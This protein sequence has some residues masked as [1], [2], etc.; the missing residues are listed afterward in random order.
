MARIFLSHSSTNNTEAIALRDWLKREGWEDVFLDV[1]PDR[2]IAAGQRWE[3][4]LHEAAS[5]CEAVLFLVSRAWL[6]SGWCLK[7]FN[8]A[9]KLNKRLF[10]LLVEDI[11]V[12]ELPFNLTS[13]WQLV[14]LC[15]S[16]DHVMLR[17]NLPFTGTEAHVT[18]SVEA[19]GRLKT[20]LQRAGLD[21][22]FFAWPPEDDPNRPPYR[23]LKPLEASDAGIF[24]GRDAAIVETLDLLRGM[25][26]G[27]PPRLPAILGASGAG[28][29]SF[30]RAGLL[31]RLARDDEDF[32]PLPIVRPERTVL[33]GDTGLLNALERALK[34][35]RIAITRAELRVAIKG[36]A[37]TLQ[38]YLQALV[39]KATR[40]ALDPGA[41]PKTPVLVL[42]IDQGE[43]L[44]L[45]E[46]QGESQDFLALLRALLTEDSPAIMAILTIRSD[47]YERL[48]L[49][50]E[51]DGLRQMTLSLPAMPR[52]SYS[53]VI[54]GPPQ[55][56]AETARAF[57]I[58]DRLVE[59]LL[60]DIEV[61]GGAKDALPLLAFTLERLY[62][63]FHAGGNLQLAHYNELGRIGGSI[64][65]AVNHALEAANTDPEVP[66]DRPRRLALL[67]QG[68]I[69]WLAGVDADTGAPR[70]RVAR[71]SEI[72]AEARPLIRHFVEQRLLTTDIARDT[73]EQTIEPAHEALLR[74]WSLL[75]GWL[76]EDAGLLAVMDGVKRAARDWAAHGK[77]HSWLTHVTGRLEA[78]ERLGARPD[79]AAH[80]LPV[81]REYLAACRKSENDGN[82]RKRR[83]QALVYILLVGIIVGLVGWMNQAAIKDEVNW[84]VTMRPYM[85][86]EVR[87][88]V[89][90]AEAERAL[91]PGS[92]FRECGRIC[93][94]MVV[95]PPG[96]FKMGSPET[97]VGHLDH[98]ENEGP[99]H[100]VRIATPF[101]VSKLDVTFEAWDACVAV[102]GCPRLS[103]S[104]WGRGQQPVINVTWIEAQQYATWFSRMTGKRYR[105]L[106]EAEWEYAAR[107][108][109]ST[110]FYWGEE[111]GAGHANCSHCGTPWDG[112]QPAPAG[113]FAPNAFGLYD[114]LGNVWEWVEDCYH[115]TYAGAPNDGSAWVEAGCAE[116]VVRG[117]SWVG[118]R[119]AP[120]PRSAYR[121]WRPPDGRTYGLGFRLAR[122][123]GP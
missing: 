2:G 80:L 56:L 69:P 119:Q 118:L 85:L 44:F 64:E 8:L 50:R 91:Q 72:P 41:M 112:K 89:L 55:R 79:L 86:D 114:M 7:E 51:L 110:A 83:V 27:A 123:L 117:G 122:T 13:T 6:A 82:S 31:P 40:P 107:A 93:P 60:K 65:A 49:A 42:S 1:D 54:K 14:R 99:Q 57:Q 21:S 30:L 10:G 25:R 98:L 39:Q 18:F 100:E 59:A 68:L 53:E 43:E 111:V 11:P 61:D 113:S 12:S 19:L 58:E 29:S 95:I 102:G 62:D 101:A 87:P 45:A 92:I 120:L 90:T 77:A 103:D 22:R 52:G 94:E 48:Q 34:K 3:R 17:V 26:D 32:L 35:A 66:R 38:P 46:A 109:T 88:Y 116:R 20:G 78:A 96:E 104:G 24:Y 97:G 16:T 115:G 106:S 70:R 75:Q 121:D 81:D 84:Y 105:L 73:G 37:K 36:G 108:G 76:T 67:R 28:K 5:R 47:N 23:G 33:T 4:A 63:E 15:G 74:Q 71:L 9:Y